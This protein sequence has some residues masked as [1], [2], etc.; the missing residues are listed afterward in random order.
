MFGSAMC[1]AL[2]QLLQRCSLQRLVVP[3]REVQE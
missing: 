1:A 3:E 2:A